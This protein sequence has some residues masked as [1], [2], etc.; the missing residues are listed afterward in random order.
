MTG[1]K[2]KDILGKK[3][4]EV[5]PGIERAQFDW[6]D[7]YGQVALSGKAT[8]FESF[9]EPLGRWYD[10]S[11]YS[12]QPGYFVTVFRDINKSK[13]TEQALIKSEDKHHRLFETMTQ[14]VIYQDKEG[15]IISANPAAERILNLSFDQIKDKTSMDPRWQMIE[16]DG[17]PVTDNDHPVMIALRTGKTVGPVTR[18]IYHPDLN[19]HIWLSITATP[20]F[21][22]GEK[23]PF[24][25]YAT[26]VDITE[27][28]LMEEHMWRYQNIVSSTSDGI[29]F[30][31][32]DYRYIIVNDA[33]E[34]FSGVKRE[35]FIGRTV[36]EYLG[37]DVFKQVVKPHFDKCLQGDTVIYQEWFEYPSLGRRFV[38]ITY[39]PYRDVL[40]NIS[41]VLSNT[42]DI[43]ERKM[44]EDK[45]QRVSFSVANLPDSIF[46]VGETG[47]FTDVNAA[48][49]RKLGYTREELLTMCVADIDPNFSPEQ[50][51]PHWEE[52][53]QCGLKVIETIHRTKD[54]VII[55]MELVIHNQH[56]GDAQYNVVLGR[57]ITDRK[58]AEDKIHSLNEELEERVRERTAQ[59]EASNRELDAFSY[60]VSHDLRGPL[61]RIKG[62]SQALLED[63][64]EQLDQQ[65]QDYL[66][67]IGN[68]SLHMA[69]LIDDLLKLS[70][71]SRMEI[72]HE[73]I[74]LSA[75]VNVC[76]IEL[77][78]R[79]PQRKLEIT[80]TPGLVVEGDT[81]LLR[82]VLENLIDNA[83]KF[84]RQEEVAQ[85]EFG[86]T[87]QANQ[88][89]YY[90]RDNGAGFDMKHAAKL[91]TAF[92]R[93]HSDQE[94]SG[95]GIGLSI[96]SRIIKRHGGKV[97][98]D[99]EPGKG[100]CFYF[101]LP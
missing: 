96:V 6:I 59:L 23:N 32:K 21:Q 81:A 79:D 95:T 56:F 19:N 44:A 52:M 31:D 14:G 53:R 91:F 71:V 43:T 34:N 87:D 75:L 73:P 20:L 65:G 94:F 2:R 38:E 80:V 7:T 5:L 69:E 41:G 47:Y 22:S 50:W 27:R 72:Y 16:E 83:W 92:Q 26:F 82:I 35:H 57:D 24:Q 66:R 74:E 63:Y 37:E 29:A 61:N 100:A 36:A 18:G 58:K 90:I 98:A 40:D 4:T 85:I 54:G 77:Q 88:S 13:T 93:L 25:A 11:A 70:K 3:V 39:S 45:L 99:G 67:R 1:L 28:K 78:A 64:S 8:R 49:C 15:K 101:T 10:V 48:A 17:T 76:L 9:S 89:A 51:A 12:D 68:S 86:L 42:R 55:P 30:L 62:F 33:Y 97:W 46:W 60:S 84:T